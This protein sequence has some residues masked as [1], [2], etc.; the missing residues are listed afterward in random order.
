MTDSYKI[1]KFKALDLPEQYSA[2][3][4]SRFLRSLR[5]GNQYFKL[6]DRKTYFTIYRSY[7]ATLLTRPR[8]AVR[9]AVLSDDFDVVLGFSITEPEKLHYVHV[10]TDYRKAGIGSSLT[11]DPFNTFTHLTN[12]SASIWS[13]KFPEAIFNPF[14]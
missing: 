12:I 6:I 1:L 14:A 2:M 7:I 9:L 4:Y 10:N 8:A 3:I 5:N 13:S 11:P